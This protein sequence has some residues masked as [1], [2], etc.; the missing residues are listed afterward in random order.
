LGAIVDDRRV[1]QAGNIRLPLVSAIRDEAGAALLALGFQKNNI[2]K[3]LNTLLKEDKEY[4]L[5]QMVKAALKS[6][7]GA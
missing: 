4:T 5:E 2:D 7:S 6:L 3:V 1:R